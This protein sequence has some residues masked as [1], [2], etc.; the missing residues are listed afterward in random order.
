MKRAFLMTA[1]CFTL[2][3]GGAKSSNYASL[4]LV[5]V[6]G[7]VT[8]DGA[9]L[10]NVKVAFENPETKTFSV[11]KTDDAGAFK[12]MFNSEKS[13]CTPGKKIVRITPYMG[14]ES[15]AEAVPSDA[16]IPPK[17]GR[18]SQLSAEVDSSK[19]NFD[20]ALTSK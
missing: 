13:G 16:K 8:M 12:L 18:I 17:Y 9:P 5:E 4:G 11:G 20:F 6:S 15:D 3:C 14:S 2:G 10:P 1:A 7:K 19:R